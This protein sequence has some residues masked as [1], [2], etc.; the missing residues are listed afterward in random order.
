MTGWVKLWCLPGRALH[1]PTGGAGHW[2][3]AWAIIDDHR[4]SFFESDQLA[5]SEH[6]KPFMSID[7]DQDHWRIYNQTAEKPVEGIRNEEMTMLIELKLS[8][9]AP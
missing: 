4:L 5:I 8:R 1:P 6:A 9:C 3:N 2:R 7:L